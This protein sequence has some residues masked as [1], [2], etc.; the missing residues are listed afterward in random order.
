MKLH[1]I[2]R[3]TPRDTSFTIRV[4]EGANFLKIWHYHPEL[5][6]VAVLKS[7]GTCFV[8]DGV[9][10]FEKGDVFLVGKDTP[11]MWLNDES[12]F[13]KESTLKAKSIAIH[14]KKDFLGTHFFD[15]PE[16]M[17]LSEFFNKARF[18]IKFLS[19]TQKQIE[20]IQTLLELK[21]FEKTISFLRILNE[22]SLSKNYKSLA[23]L[24]YIKSFQVTKNET[25]DRV[26]AYIFK[27]FKENISLVEVAKIANMNATAFSRLFKRV[28]GKTYS[29][30][31]S[32]I[33]IGYA[34]R[35]LLEQK[36][37]ISEICYE[38]GFNNVSNFNR[39]FKIIKKCSPSSYIKTHLK[40][41]VV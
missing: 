7:E 10:K 16:M 4:N 15:T 30:Y 26:Y 40:N 8:G 31:L 20:A 27:H 29:R 28:N 21:G 18:G 39:Q 24:G 3:S 33:R 32:E 22:L 34:C 23:S 35:L 25:L 13:A 12:Y 19:V 6:L 1:L 38:V 5:E 17:H 37:N 41:E 2:D 14:F 36:V 11:H 9:E